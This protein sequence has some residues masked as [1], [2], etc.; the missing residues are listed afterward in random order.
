MD[1]YSYIKK[2]HLKVAGLMEDVI[3]SSNPT[4]RL[5][6]FAQI[7][8]DLLLHLTAE[9]QTFYK[10]IEG[11]TRAQAV[12]EQMAHAEHEHDEVRQYIEKISDLSPNQERWIETF[13]EFKHAVSHHVEEEEGDVWKKAK[14][15]LSH[16]QAVQLA[17][18]MA[19]VK[20]ELARQPTPMAIAE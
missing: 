6:L 4:E 18:D 5:H 16:E 19:A 10:A 3:K 17:K 9:E 2:D 13:G 1:I 14:K 7:K 12:E 11:A 8:T 15:Y 20:K